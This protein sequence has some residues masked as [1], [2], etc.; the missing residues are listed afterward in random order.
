MYQSPK[1]YPI[2]KSRL[3]RLQSNAEDLN[4]RV[5][6][7]SERTKEC[8]AALAEAEG[9]LATERKQGWHRPVHGDSHAE[10]ERRALQANTAESVRLAS[11]TARRDE[12]AAAL[13]FARAEHAE[14]YALWG[15]AGR[16]ASA[17]TEYVRNSG[18][19]A[20]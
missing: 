5:K 9:A 2:E 15:A 7:L 10:V 6:K 8:R 18:R 19:S 14:I 3:R 16:L 4:D 12:A 20:S 11:L 1:A 17:C 13:E